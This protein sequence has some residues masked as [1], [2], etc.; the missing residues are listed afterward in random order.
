[1]VSVIRTSIYVDDELDFR[2][3][4]KSEGFDEFHLF[5]SS[6]DSVYLNIH[7]ENKTSLFTYKLRDVEGEYK[8]RHSNTYYYDLDQT[9]DNEA[10]ELFDD[11]NDY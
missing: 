7:F 8:D 5:P 10:T 3:F 11:D 2:N 1:M 4:L 6:S 9:F